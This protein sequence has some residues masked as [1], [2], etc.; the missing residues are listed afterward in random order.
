MRDAL[1]LVDV[2]NAFD[3]E[4]GDRLLES[5]RERHGGL[6]R[7]L[8][9]ARE[10]QLPVVYANDNVGV[11]DGDARGLVERA[12]AGKGG[13]LVETIAPRDGDLFV[14]K[15]R[16]S[17]F[18]HTPLELLLRDLE[19]ERLLL[20]GTATEMCVVQTAIAARERGFKVSVLVDACATADERME[21]ISLDYV[22]NVIGAR[23]EHAAA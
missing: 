6:V 4:D 18:D 19:I 15:P 13:E 22:E 8:E 9:D 11:W 2:I 3:H 14:I 10:A 16:Y 7:A 1:L 12:V 5:F 17:A 20:A 23:L 21:R